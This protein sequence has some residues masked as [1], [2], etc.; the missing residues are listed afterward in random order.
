MVF[1]LPNNDVAL[2]VM[3]WHV[4]SGMSFTSTFANSLSDQIA[5]AWTNN[6][7]SATT[8][9]AYLER[10]VIED[11]RTTPYVSYTRVHHQA[12]SDSAVALPFQVASVMSLHTAVGG[13]RGRGRV[14]L[15]GFCVDNV[16]AGG[17]MSSALLSAISD[18]ATALL[19]ITTVSG[20]A[21]A[22]SVLSRKFSQIETIQQV[23]TDNRF[24][25]Q[26]RRA[27][28]RLP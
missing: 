5:T 12:G 10:G 1:T 15:P 8:S 24:D 11:L 3:H 23:T 13:R 28:V 25:V 2:N 19:A 17:V 22:W 14:Y 27:N 6:L 9:G 16:A 20:D 26:R 4:D 21:V 18:Y 7:K